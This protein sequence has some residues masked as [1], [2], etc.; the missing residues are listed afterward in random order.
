MTVHHSSEWEVKNV[1]VL[2]YP[3]PGVVFWFTD[4]AASAKVKYPDTD[5][6]WIES[7]DMTESEDAV[8]AERRK[9][10]EEM[11]AVVDAPARD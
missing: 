8:G 1:L 5:F 11:D 10:K 2:I 6:K 9:L 3:S 4:K 7:E